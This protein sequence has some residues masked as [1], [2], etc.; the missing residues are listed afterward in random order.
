MTYDFER[1]ALLLHVTEGCRGLPRLKALHDAAMTEL[2]GMRPT[3]AEP[4]QPELE[5]NVR[6]L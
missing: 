5:E 1:A 6:R 3:I 2:E 4:N